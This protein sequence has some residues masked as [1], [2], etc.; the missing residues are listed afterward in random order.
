[1]LP[2]RTARASAMEGS[3]VSRAGVV[4]M[5]WV[6]RRAMAASPSKMPLLRERA[7]LHSEAT[8]TQSLL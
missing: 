2:A 6:R 8:L 1:V 4:G 5:S 3:E 7:E